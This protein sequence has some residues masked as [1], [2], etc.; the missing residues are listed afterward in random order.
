MKTSYFHS[1]RAI[2][3]IILMISLFLRIGLV[4][5]GG[6]FFNPDEYRYLTSR[7]I[8]RDIQKS[9]YKSAIKEAT[10]AADHLG[11]KIIG[12]LPALAEGKYG[13]NPFIPSFFFS[14]F[15]WLNIMLVW[16]LARRLGGD[17]KESLW[18]VLFAAC[19]NTLFYYSSHLYPYDIALTF[20]LVALYFGVDETPGVWKSLLVGFLGFLTFFTYNGYW[21]LTAF[22]FILHV[23]RTSK[24]NFRMLLKAFAAGAGFITP[25][26]FIVLISRHYGNDLWHSYTVFS[27]TI[28]NGLFSEG[29]VLPFKYFWSAEGLIFPVW[30][31]LT[32]LSMISLMKRPSSRATI[33]LA[34]LFFIYG[35]LVISSVFLHKFV[36]YARL[37]RQLVPFL[38]LSSAYGINML[39]EEIRPR[40]LASIIFPAF[41]L[42]QAGINF[43]R[44]FLI[45]YP[46]DFAN[47]IQKIYPDFIPPKNMTFF[48][49]PNSIDVGPYKA[50]NIKFVF[51]LPEAQVPAGEEVL[52]NAVNPLSSF[53]PFLFDE[54]YTPAERDHFPLIK[55][56]V[57]RIKR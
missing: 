46:R 20:G 32:L 6:Q 53:S 48:Y 44:P 15:S 54:G 28:T 52:M 16:L 31:L 27:Q 37:A 39:L 12:V 43:H 24:F 30:L 50:Y 7:S 19:S 5:H 22:V 21:T 33:W 29:G 38:A 55:M 2:L 9:H 17:E 11:F 51:P 35:S 25:F 26:Y 57:T 14:I 8:A 34:G 18:A 3:L 1:P 56:V 45:T 42:L 4:V 49:T 10:Q 36:V 47:Q 23:S 13:E 41:L 40:R